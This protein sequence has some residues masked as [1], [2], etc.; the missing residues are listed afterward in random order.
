[1]PNLSSRGIVSNMRCV[2]QGNA[3]APRRPSQAQ[4]GNTA[5][6]G[7]A[8]TSA[9]TASPIN[10][11]APVLVIVGRF[12]HCGALSKSGSLAIFAAIGRAS[13]GRQPSCGSIGAV[14]GS[15]IKCDHGSRSSFMDR[16]N[17]RFKDRKALQAD[18]GA[19]YNAGIISRGQVMLYRLPGRSIRTDVAD[20][21]LP[22]PVCHLSQR[23]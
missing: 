18:T 17:N 6:V 2:F 8:N 20:I 15:R 3:G 16:V 13:V 10:S 5:I 9:P 22:S 4:T 19:N 7:G 1:M 23:K 21:A 11:A 14:F 12:D